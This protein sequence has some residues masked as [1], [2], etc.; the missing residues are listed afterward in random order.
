MRESGTVLELEETALKQLFHPT[1]RLS[2]R[3]LDALCA[4]LLK[5]ITRANQVRVRAEGTRRR[6]NDQP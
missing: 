2:Y 5:D 1:D 3:F 4:R 6:A